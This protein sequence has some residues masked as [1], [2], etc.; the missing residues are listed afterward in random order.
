MTRR[1]LGAVLGVAVVALGAC[2]D[3]RDAASFCDAVATLRGEDPFAELD[4]A[5]PEQMRT[6]FSELQELA[7]EVRDLAP[8]DVRPRAERYAEAVDAV[9]EELTGAAYDPRLLDPLRY[10]RATRDY[11]EAAVRLD[12]AAGTVC[13]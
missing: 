10:R 8:P 3:D 9:V 7:D 13:D 5:R 1:A 12:D 11:T 4:V 6:A 2:D